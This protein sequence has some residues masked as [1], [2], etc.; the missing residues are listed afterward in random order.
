MLQ[1]LCPPLLLL[2]VL[3]WTA[4]ARRL[5]V[6]SSGTRR[7][8]QLLYTQQVVEIS[9]TE[10]QWHK[11]ALGQYSCSGM[12]FGLPEE[13]KLCGMESPHRALKCDG[14]GMA[15][16]ESMKGKS[17]SEIYGR[18]MQALKDDGIQAVIS[19]DGTYAKLEQKV[20]EA[21]GLEWYNGEGDDSF[22][23]PD[24]TVPK[25][26]Q[27]LGFAKLVDR[28]M[29]RSDI[30][31]VVM[32]CYGGFG[33]TGVYL[34]AYASWRLS[35]NLLPA[36][37]SVPEV[38]GFFPFCFRLH[39]DR[40]SFMELPA[41][42]VNAIILVMGFRNPI[43]AQR[44]GAMKYSGELDYILAHQPEMRPPSACDRL[45]Q[46]YE[47][48]QNPSWSLSV[49][50]DPVGSQ[51]NIVLNCVTEHGWR[52][53]DFP[54]LITDRRDRDGHTEAAVSDVIKDI[55]GALKQLQSQAAS[56]QLTE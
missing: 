53:S 6:T 44:P 9:E 30:K 8:T 34:M 15:E 19:V 33:R 24:Y 2:L 51:D 43:H 37:P 18:Q 50:F 54:G 25:M 1:I 36:H 26:Y 31:G 38:S 7:F 20:A 13:K 28:L 40:G 23:L 3:V 45:T 48:L 41:D 21:A 10:D 46:F 12:A 22:V 4:G 35:R 42:V 55:A 29:Q 56:S 11:S 49:N 52:P 27:L 47:C 32:H 17:A 39:P 16:C 5:S 14:R